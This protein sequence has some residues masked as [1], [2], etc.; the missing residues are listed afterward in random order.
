LRELRILELR[1]PYQFSSPFE[2]EFAAMIV[3]LD[4]AMNAEEQRELSAALV[5]QGCRYAVCAGI[6][7]SSCDDSL[8]W[9]FLESVNF[10]PA[11]ERFVMTS[12]HDEETPDDVVFFF[13][14]CTTFGNFEPSRFVAVFLG[15]AP[16]P[17]YVA[18]LHDAFAGT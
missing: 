16:D 12:W 5:A 6:K 17:A 1:R 9:A 2:G 13:A 10:E 18:A 3:A 11:D 15:S 14:N 4:P 7:A 8:D